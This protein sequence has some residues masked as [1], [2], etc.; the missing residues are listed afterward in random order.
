MTSPQIWP[1]GHGLDTYSENDKITEI[2]KKATAL[3]DMS[4]T[5]E[6][7]SDESTTNKE[8][9]RDT[10]L[11]FKIEYAKLEEEAKT[12]STEQNDLYLKKVDIMNPDV[13]G[14]GL[15]NYLDCTKIMMIYCTETNKEGYGIYKT[16]DAVKF[17]N[18]IATQASTQTPAIFNGTEIPYNPP[19]NNNRKKVMYDYAYR[20]QQLGFGYTKTEEINEGINK[21]T[22]PKEVNLLDSLTTSEYLFNEDLMTATNVFQ[23]AAE[24][25]IDQGVGPQTLEA[26]STADSTTI[27]KVLDINAINAAKEEA[28]EGL[29]TVEDYTFSYDEERD[30][31]VNDLWLTNNPYNTY[32]D[33]FITA[34]IGKYEKVTKNW[35]ITYRE[36]LK[37]E[38]IPDLESTL[39][40]D[41]EAY[42]NTIQENLQLLSEGKT[43]FE[44]SYSTDNEEYNVGSWSN[45]INTVTLSDPE[46]DISE[47]KFTIPLL[48]KEWNK[49]S[50]IIFSNNG[51]DTRDFQPGVFRE[52]WK[53]K[54]KKGTLK[55]YEVTKEQNNN[56][57]IT[58]TDTDVID[59][60]SRSKLDEVAKEE[61]TKILQ[62]TGKITVA[63]D[64]RVKNTPTMT[65]LNFKNAQIIGGKI[66]IDN[67]NEEIT[68]NGQKQ[69]ISKVIV[70]IEAFNINDNTFIVD[71]EIQITYW[72]G[73]TEKEDK[74]KVSSRN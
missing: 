22:I 40:N 33:D 17:Y 2:E 48:D 74:F 20:L 50:D 57:K 69:I 55:K 19:K 11:N 51:K 21:K 1:S 46:T 6:Y 63:L 5:I 42:L 9:L 66:V 32:I 35:T 44:Y 56:N 18:T 10:K 23:D 45:N 62:K 65:P 13:D 14:R 61:I 36:K 8:T 59:A 4:Q 70:P 67:M 49:V 31:Y 24:I 39:T 53:N 34:T 60:T 26:L 54:I 41:L 25:N 16:G 3:F 71:T 47:V 64:W 30:K 52:K 12:D 15:D 38:V 29:E 72:S 43:Q 68:K 73:W 7:I 27:T 37:T 28:N 58:I